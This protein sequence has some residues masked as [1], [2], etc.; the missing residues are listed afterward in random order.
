MGRRGAGTAAGAG[1]GCPMLAMGAGAQPAES[2]LQGEE[3]M[4]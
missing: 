3:A 1:G 2:L 4:S